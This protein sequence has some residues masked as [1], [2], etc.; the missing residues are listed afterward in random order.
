[1]LWTR[2]WAKRMHIVIHRSLRL[3]RVHLGPHVRAVIVE[4][5]AKSCEGE[6]SVEE[7]DAIPKMLRV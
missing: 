3:E 5:N 2:T 4:A 1:M 7:P 6:V